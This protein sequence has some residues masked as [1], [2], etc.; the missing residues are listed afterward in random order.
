MLDQDWNRQRVQCE[1]QLMHTIRRSACKK[2]TSIS[3]CVAVI[4]KDIG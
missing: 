1:F 4:N 2:T 3:S